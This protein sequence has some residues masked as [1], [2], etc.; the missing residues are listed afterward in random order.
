MKSLITIL[1]ALSASFPGFA[2]VITDGEF[3]DWTF[4]NPISDPT[5]DQQ[6]FDLTEAR[7]FN[8]SLA[9]HFYI[10]G[11]DFWQLNSEYGLTLYIDTDF[12]DQTGTPFADLGADLIWNFAQRN[13]TWQGATVEHS[14]VGMYSAPTVTS[15]QFEVAFSKHNGLQFGDSIRFV[16]SVF[17]G[18]DDRLPDTGSITY[19]QHGGSYAYT[20]IDLNPSANALRVMTYN[21]EHDGLADPV[22]SAALGRVIAAADP[23]IITFN[24]LWDTDASYV[25]T[26][27]NGILP[28]NGAMWQTVK[29]FNGNVTASRYPITQSYEFEPG[30]RVLITV[31]DLPSNYPS[32]IVIANLHLKCCDDDDRRQ[33]QVDNLV[34]FYRDLHT[35]MG[36]LNVPFA[37]PFIV[38]GDMN[39]VGDRA[40]IETVL[41]GDV[42]QEGTY[43]FDFVPDWD[44]SP[45]K[46]VL[47]YHTDQRHAYTWPGQGSSYYPGRLDFIFYS[48]YVLQLEKSF[49]LNTD[50]MSSAR[51]TTTGLVAN[52]AHLASDHLPVIADFVWNNVS[53][54][55]EPEKPELLIRPN[56]AE[57]AATLSWRK[58]TVNKIEVRDTQGRLLDQFQVGA[59]EIT[60]DLNTSDYPAQPLWIIVDG[61]FAYPLIVQ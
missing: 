46:E 43:G 5:G 47:P 14:D 55:S 57:E 23:D 10:Q 18:V 40:Q 19:R 37:T 58:G 9:I 13:G 50:G 34:D 39:F 12:D 48:D 15:D 2:Q 33:D 61:Q 7:V 52:D 11:A 30:D 3:S 20:P 51:L 49:V 44:N 41:N 21:V 54:I 28:L 32:D 45:L 4:I 27:L 53:G 56:P 59:D 17:Q 26:F 60:R 16:W 1:L 8:D 24:E 42:V 25:A 22:H 36:N 38:M 29:L 35:P 6:Y 31:I